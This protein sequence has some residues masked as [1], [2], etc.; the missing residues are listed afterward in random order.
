[1][2]KFPTDMPDNVRHVIESYPKSAQA[3]ALELRHIIVDA[4]SGDN[5]I[6]A[7]TE[8]L[9]WNEPA[10]LTEKTKSGTTVRYAWKVKSPNEI[11]VFLNCQTTLIR[12]FRDLF[13]GDLKFEGNRAIRLSLDAPLPEDILKL[14][15][16]TA[17]TYK[18]QDTP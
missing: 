15:F 4:A 14:C 18:I 3:K 17:L 16:Q 8:T 1:M 2:I 7:L 10:Y 12:T 9:K 5:R 11:G 6:G 13:T